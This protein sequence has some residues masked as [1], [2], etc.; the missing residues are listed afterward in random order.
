MS[1]TIH[2]HGHDPERSSYCAGD[3]LSGTVHLKGPIRSNGLTVVLNFFG[4]SFII[5][6][7]RGEEHDDYHNFL[8]K[9]V[10]LFCGRCDLAIDEDMSWGFCLK[11]P[12]NTGEDGP[13][14][15]DMPS[16]AIWTR[17][18]HP[19]PPSVN[20]TRRHTLREGYSSEIKYGLVASAWGTYVKLSKKCSLR[21]RSLREY[22][23]LIIPKTIV[24]RRYID[25]DGKT[26]SRKFL[27]W[28]QSKKRPSPTQVR[29]R[30]A[31]PE[32]MELGTKS[33]VNLNI[34]QERDGWNSPH[35]QGITLLSVKHE[36][37]EEIWSRVPREGRQD[38]VWTESWSTKKFRYDDP[39]KITGT[40]RTID[41]TDDLNIALPK[42][43]HTPSFKTY[44]L[45]KK[46]K[47]ITTIKLK[48]M[49][50]VKKMTFRVDNLEVLP[51]RRDR[52]AK[53]NSWT[54]RA[55]FRQGL[56]EVIK[57]P[58][59]SD[60]QDSDR[61]EEGRRHMVCFPVPEKLPVVEVRLDD[62]GDES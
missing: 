52:A 48:H 27:G 43:L 39:Q 30:M 60:L 42:N 40:D 3:S 59:L 8:S 55:C 57:V 35:G 10:L 2:I 32:V 58:R 38:R 36:I 47:S 51:A 5:L 17:D 1:L 12:S 45:S 26:K 6:P 18:S 44:G 62:D 4:G 9:K 23:D 15:P 11:F 31:I 54:G 49:G 34:S 21:F 37:L 7:E 53:Q 19:L 25:F 46:Y 22:N 33:K 41:L 50:E 16:G 14:G 29:L 28:L 56:G 24:Q 61:V 13:F 20:Y